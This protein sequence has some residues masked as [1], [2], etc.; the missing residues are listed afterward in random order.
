MESE[1]SP[2]LDVEDSSHDN[3]V[4]FD[5]RKLSNTPS[6][7]RR[8]NTTKQSFSA[9]DR[10]WTWFCSILGLGFLVL[11]IILLKRKMPSTTTPNGSTLSANLG[12]HGASANSINIKKSDNDA[13]TYEF[14]VLKNGL[15]VVLVSDPVATKAAA[16]MDVRVGHYSDPIEIPGLAH[17]LEHMLFLGTKKYPSETNF[18]EYLSSNGGDSNAYT[19]S[20]STNYH[21]LIDAEKEE[22]VQKSLDMFSQ[23]FEAPLLLKESI[24]REK[25]AVIAEHSKN[26]DQDSWRI[27]QVL[28]ST[29]NTNYP[30]HKFG[31]GNVDSLKDRCLDIREL[32]DSPNTDTE[33][34]V[35]KTAETTDTSFLRLSKSNDGNTTNAD[36]KKQKDQDCID[37]HQ[38][39]VRFHQKYY[40]ANLM[41]LV[42]VGFQSTEQLSEWATE[43]FSNIPNKQIDL[44]SDSFNYPKEPVRLPSQLGI[45]INVVPVSDLRQLRLSWY[46]PSQVKAYRS[47]VTS[48]L[49]NVLGEE[50]KGSIRSVLYKEGLINSLMAGVTEQTTDFLIFSITLD[51]TVNGEKR[52][53]YVTTVVYNYLKMLRE[54]GPQKWFFDEQAKLANVDLLYFAKP[55]SADTASTLASNLQMYDAEDVVVSD[56]LWSDWAP[57]GVE[58]ALAEMTPS[59]MVMVC[60]SKTYETT[61][62]EPIYGTKYNPL[63]IHPN[64][65]VSWTKGSDIDGSSSFLSFPNSNI[66]I[67]TD[68]TSLSGLDPGI[69]AEAVKTKPETYPVLITL[70]DDDEEE[71]SQEDGTNTNNILEVWYK[72]DDTFGTFK[73][74]KLNCSKLCTILVVIIVKPFKYFFLVYFSFNAFSV[75]IPFKQPKNCH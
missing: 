61:K 60:I 5:A 59:N 9:A 55:S 73:I 26:I 10:F 48:Y 41:R 35:S 20:E 58:A 62:I 13:R 4:L 15:Q 2:L 42:I 70:E 54:L 57:E 33:N 44:P 38:S 40:S 27:E 51:L 29:S 71:N 37:L 11:L 50:S 14:T 49:A 6:S 66:W 52:I 24:A 68:F 34:T 46:I 23:F 18:N 75:I 8:R 45:R 36:Q 31:T 1:N 39:L 22:V 64:N 74:Q 7:K 19:D 3:V 32:H 30:Y 16:A 12:F 25:K 67:P 69:Q 56:Y 63:T 53:K 65:I 28:R 21:F 17:L 43:Y 72:L 47:K